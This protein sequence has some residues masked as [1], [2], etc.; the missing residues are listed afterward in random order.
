MPL[1][2][3]YGSNM[4]IDRMRERNIN[5]TKR[6]PAILFGYKLTFNKMSSL[7]REGFATIEKGNK[8][9]WVE[10][11]LYEIN[12]MG[13]FNLDRYEGYPYH[14][15]RVKIKVKCD[16]EDMIVTTYIATDGTN[17]Y[18][19]KPSQDYLHHL[20]KGKDILSEKYFEK[21]LKWLE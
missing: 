9:D 13:I 11:A 2:F 16:C 8:F 10:G 20:L 3:A 1:Y 5:F 14:Y 15:K 18:N 12:N 19:L 7:I 4:D 21:L 6:L 17:G